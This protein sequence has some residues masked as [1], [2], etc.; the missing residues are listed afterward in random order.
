MIIALKLFLSFVSNIEFQRTFAYLNNDVQFLSSF[1]IKNYLMHCYDEI[2]F[3]LLSAFS[4]D[5]TKILLSLNCWSSF[6]RQEYLDVNAYFIDDKWIYHEVLLT[7]EHVTKSHIDTRLAKIIQDIISQHKLQNR[8]LVITNDNVDNNL[9]MHVK[10]LRL[11]RTRMFDDV[12][13]NVQNIKRVSC[14]AHV[15]QLTLRELL[16]RIRIN[17]KNE[18]FR[19]SWNDKQDKADMKKE[20]KEISYILIKI[21]YLFFFFETDLIRF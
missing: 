19:T 4:N 13:L 17:S 10:L 15:I 20:K 21:S 5:D 3:E 9:T 1:T 7:F 11:L 2:Q 14:L 16:D 6:N 8:I 18:S 12:E